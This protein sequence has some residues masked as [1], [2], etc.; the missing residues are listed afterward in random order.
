MKQFCISLDIILEAENKD[1]AF[2]EV[3]KLVKDIRDFSVD[4]YEGDMD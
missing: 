1:K 2:E 3:S 4:I